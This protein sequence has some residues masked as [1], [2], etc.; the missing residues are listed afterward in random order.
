MDN[1]PELGA[2]IPH[3]RYEILPGDAGIRQTLYLMRFIA[4]DASMDPR[5]RSLGINIVADINPRDDIKRAGAVLEWVQKNIR[6]VRDITR[7]ETLQ[8]PQRTLI[9]RAGDCDDFS[10]LI[11]VILLALGFAE[12]GFVAQRRLPEGPYKHVFVVCKIN[13]LKYKN[14]LRYKN[15]SWYK[16]DGTGKLPIQPMPWDRQKHYLE[17]I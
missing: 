11:A 10:I 16:M 12:I 2:Q 8:W 9:W 14:G 17:R 6:Y 5:L 1:Y 7:C 13:V 4:L 15:G 3:A